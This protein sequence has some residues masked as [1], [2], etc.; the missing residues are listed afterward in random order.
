LLFFFAGFSVLSPV[1]AFSVYRL[2]CSIKIHENKLLFFANAG[3][4]QMPIWACD[5]KEN[6]FVMKFVRRCLLLLRRI[7]CWL[8]IMEFFAF[9]T[10]KRYYHKTT[11]WMKHRWP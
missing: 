6:K 2:G 10:M 9:L 7:L 5:K 8:Q 1:V 4:L 11:G 3:F